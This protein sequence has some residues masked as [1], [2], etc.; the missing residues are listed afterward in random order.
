MEQEA[1][2]FLKAS[3]LVQQG[4]GY[5]LKVPEGITRMRQALESVNLLDPE[6]LISDVSNTDDEVSA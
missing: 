4:S 5:L 2:L 6:T 1:N 3:S